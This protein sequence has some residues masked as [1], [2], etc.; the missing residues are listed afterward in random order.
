M[1]KKSPVYCPFPGF[2]TNGRVLL[3][4]HMGMYDYRPYV[5]IV[6]NG[7]QIQYECERGYIVKG[8][9]GATC[10]DSHWKPKE[11]PTCVKG[12]HPNI[13]ND[14]QKM[15]RKRRSLYKK[16]IRTHYDTTTA[17]KSRERRS[18]KLPYKPP[19]PLNLKKIPRKLSMRLMR[20]GRHP[21]PK[22]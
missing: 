14:D 4:G 21:R 13:H 9:P 18:S 8:A 16:H 6:P 2:L 22:G 1:L 3:V 19:Y 15:F 11:L 7:K 17:T 10:I 12:V 20:G 5:K